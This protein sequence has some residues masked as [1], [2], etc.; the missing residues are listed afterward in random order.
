MIG[1]TGF[2]AYIRD[3]SHL[4]LLSLILISDCDFCAEWPQPGPVSAYNPRQNMLVSA[5]NNENVPLFI[6]SIKGGYHMFTQQKL[7]V[8]NL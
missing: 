1:I 6:T 5:Y 8:V 2:I 7:E 3:I 4:G